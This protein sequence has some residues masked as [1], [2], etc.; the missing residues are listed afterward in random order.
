MAEP[1]T[2]NMRIARQV[3]EEIATGGNLDLVAEVFAEDAVEHAPF[4]QDAR[5]LE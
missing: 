4:D 3:P 2:E 1:I 5:G